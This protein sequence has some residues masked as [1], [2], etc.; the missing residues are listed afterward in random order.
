MKILALSD[1]VVEFI[2]SPALRERYPDLDLL[3]ACGDLPP[4]YLEYAITLLNIP[5]VFV[6]GNHD[7]DQFRVPGGVNIDGKLVSVQ[8]LSIIGLGGSR[9][10][11]PKGRHQYTGGEMKIRVIRQLFKLLLRPRLARRGIDLFVSHAP[12]KGIHDRED[13]AHQGFSAFHWLLQLARPRFML[14]GHSHLF[15]GLENAETEAYGVR[16]INVFPYRL[17]EV[18]VGH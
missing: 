11:K 2:H 8:G 1:E 6:P 14:H 7:A 16:V 5:L 18:E 13:W 15:R 4:S 17:V 12:P 3:V 9:R 10:Y